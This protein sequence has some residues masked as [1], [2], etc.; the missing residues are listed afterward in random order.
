MITI[1]VITILILV[2]YYKSLNKL[3]EIV[4]KDRV[5]LAQKYLEQS[6]KH[7][8]MLMIAVATFLLGLLLVNVCETSYEETYTYWF[9]GDRT[10]TRTVLT[11]VGWMSYL[12]LVLGGLFTLINAI[13]Y[14]RNKNK[15]SEYSSMSDEQYYRLQ[16]KAQDELDKENKVVRCP[17]CR[18]TRVQEITS[19]KSMATA[20][21][22]GFMDGMLGTNTLKNMQVPY[23]CMDCGNEFTSTNAN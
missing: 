6:E 1:T 22:L 4:D 18:S 3:N 21:G 13:N 9:F 17:H 14:Q 20:V 19:N 8:K 10:G 7:K 15:Y 2:W 16:I 12:F 23:K 11:G 5:Q